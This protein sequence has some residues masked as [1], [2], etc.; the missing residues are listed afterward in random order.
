LVV[1]ES[2]SGEVDSA[3]RIVYGTEDEEPRRG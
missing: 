2:G 1:V 3:L